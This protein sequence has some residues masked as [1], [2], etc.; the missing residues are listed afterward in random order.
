MRFSKPTCKRRK[1]NMYVSFCNDEFMNEHTCRLLSTRKVK[2]VVYI[3]LLT[4]YMN[5]CVYF[6]RALIFNAATDIK[7]GKFS[8]RCVVLWKF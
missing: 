1:E 5:K 6:P 2:R 7:K 3:Y 8:L 4:I